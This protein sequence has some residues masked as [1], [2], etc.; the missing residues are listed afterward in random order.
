MHIAVGSTNIV[1]V[2]AVKQAVAHI[3]PDVVVTGFETESGVSEQPMSDA[4]T[5]LGSM[6]RA[7][8]ALNM[9]EQTHGGTL[10]GKEEMFLGV[11]LEGG[12]DET[13]EGL[14]NVVWCSVV[15][16]QEHFYSSSGA[17]FLLPPVIANPILAGEEMGPVM[18]TLVKDKDTKKKGGM[19]GIVTDGFFNR[20]DEYASI[21]RMTIGLWYGR[22]W[23]HTLLAKHQR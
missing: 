21:A 13:P 11:G 1:K 9:L 6:N 7:I 22:N 2:N 16:P 20:T 5:K 3:W 18:D 12:V 23:E 10:F 17:R 8:Q 15:D 14:M 19:I 4:E